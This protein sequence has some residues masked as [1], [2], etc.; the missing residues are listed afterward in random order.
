MKAPH[1]YGGWLIG[2]TLLRHVSRM[3]LLLIGYLHWRLGLARQMQKVLPNMVAKRAA[4]HP[5]HK[6]GQ[7]HHDGA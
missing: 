6:H 4:D 1:T 7:A 5:W 3:Q 2:L